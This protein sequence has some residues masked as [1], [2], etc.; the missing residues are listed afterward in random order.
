MKYL[1]F[2]MA[3][4]GSI[5]ALAL[6]KLGHDVTCV[7][8]KEANLWPE[9]EQLKEMLGSERLLQ[10]GRIG[11]STIS[12]FDYI[13]LSPGIPRSIELLEEVE[14]SKIISDIEL[15]SQ[16][17]KIPIIAITGTNGKTTTTLMTKAALESV[18]QKVFIAG[19]I[20]I[21]VMSYFL[22][23]NNFDVILLELS[24]FQLESCF[25]FHPKIAAILNISANHMERYDNIS[26]YRAAKARITQNQKEG[27]Y[28]VIDELLFDQ[29]STTAKKIII[30]KNSTC[31][32]IGLTHNQYN[33]NVA[34]EIV[35][36]FCNKNVDEDRFFKLYTPPKY[37][38]EYLGQIGSMKIY[39]DSKSTNQVATEQAVKSCGAST[40]LILGG[41]LR[42]GDD[43]HWVNEL[44]HLLKEVIV[45]GESANKISNDLSVAF[46]TVDSYQDIERILK[47]YKG[48]EVNII[49]SP[50]LPSFDAFKSFEERGAFFQD[51]V[52]RV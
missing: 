9:F 16:L 50:S 40:V 6:N 33:F 26:D 32:K 48:K 18:D 34:T 36:L 23:E 21:A 3:R 10:Q 37:R 5:S 51:L 14:A 46:R 20:G 7:D 25:S 44:E 13:V 52:A 41:K 2:G 22:Q 31:S 30:D 35:K 45:V 8:M 17:V 19:N 15:F 24:S 27:D 43:F 39:N 28:L 42:G 47:E 12:N 29:I 11:K 38:M 1:V 49:F 4:T